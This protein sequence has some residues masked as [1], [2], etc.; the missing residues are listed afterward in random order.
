MNVLI[1]KIALFFRSYKNFTVENLLKKDNKDKMKNA[2]KQ[3]SNETEVKCSLLCCGK[4][5]AVGK[6]FLHINENHIQK[7]F[8]QKIIA[9]GG[10]YL[11]SN[12]K[13]GVL[14]VNTTKGKHFF[15]DFKISQKCPH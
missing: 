14:I 15:T 8:S 11:G 12:K 4:N 7:G 10:Y 2:V 13:G 5:V 1:E 3:F 6:F 9:A